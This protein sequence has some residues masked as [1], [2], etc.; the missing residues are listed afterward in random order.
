MSMEVSNITL[1]A[2]RRI[3]S[4]GKRFDSRTLTKYRD[5][6]VSL[7]VS[8]TAEGSARVVLGK[9]E[10]I[11]GV[12]LALDKPYPDSPDKG[13][14]MVSA[15]LLPMASPRYE[16][17]PPKFD[18]I[19]LP[20]LVDRVIRESHV[21]KLDELCV[22]K[23][24]K[25]W[26]V[27]INIYPI[28]SDGN[29]IDAATIGAII[30]LKNAFIPGVDEAGR[31]DYKHR[32]KKKIPLEENVPLSVSFYKMGDSIVLD[33]TREEEEAMDAKVT[34]GVS[35]WKGK[36]MIHSCQKGRETPF[37]QKEIESMMEILPETY[38]GLIERLKKF[39]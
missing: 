23:G 34:F 15:D 21:I 35:K 9:T 8:N 28:N 26:T 18:A 38:D 10:V 22:I 16:V 6:K 33:P 17:G 4:E 32:T 29:L 5:L 24:E 12:K 13:N 19:E 37:S 39:L 11:V 2:L 7:D 30:A 20:R 14:L 31:P 27:I 36:H 3:F 1:E 25:V